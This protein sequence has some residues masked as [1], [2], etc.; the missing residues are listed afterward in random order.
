M[1][2]EQGCVLRCEEFRPT[3]LVPFPIYVCDNPQIWEEELED[4]PRDNIILLLEACD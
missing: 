1:D 2:I 3:L 4:S